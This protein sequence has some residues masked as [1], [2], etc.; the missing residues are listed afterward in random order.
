MRVHRMDN[1]PRPMSWL[2]NREGFRF[3]GVKKD[4]THI[5]CRVERGPDGLHRV[6]DGMLIHLV[7]WFPLPL[8]SG[9]THGF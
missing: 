7:G 5:E 4:G 2:P 9:T 6:A 3:I 1:K 8:N